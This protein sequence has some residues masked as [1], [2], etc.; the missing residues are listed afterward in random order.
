MCESKDMIKAIIVSAFL[1]LGLASSSHAQDGDRITQLEKEVQE[2]KL[3]LS[4]LESL[5]GNQS[6]FQEPVTSGEP[7]K[8]IANWRKLT[9][10]MSTSDVRTILGEPQRID[11]GAF[12][13]WSYENHGIV[14]F[15]EG[16][17]RSWNE[18]R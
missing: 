7:W 6:K 9:V 2:L 16:K 14:S 8:A 11:G 13:A 10:G 5:V 4:K 17:V 15:A 3:R 1:S 18:P 12:Q